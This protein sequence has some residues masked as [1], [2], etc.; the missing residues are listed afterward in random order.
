[1]ET[2][3]MIRVLGLGSRSRQVRR[4]KQVLYRAVSEYSFARF[5]QSLHPVEPSGSTNTTEGEITRRSVGRSFAGAV[6]AGAV[7]LLAGTMN[8]QTQ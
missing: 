5:G 3:A 8:V 7:L 1:M 2:K 4:E 6:G